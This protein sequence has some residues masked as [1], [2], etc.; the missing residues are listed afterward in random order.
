MRFSLVTFTLVAAVA[1][2][3]AAL[4][5]APASSAA[6]SGAEASARI[7]ATPGGAWKDAKG[8][9]HEG[10]DVS[11]L[12]GNDFFRFANGGWLASTEIPKDRDSWG[13]GAQVA[14]LTDERTAK[15][16]REVDPARGDASARLVADYFAA[17]MDESAIESKGLAPIAKRL[18]A[19]SDIKSKPALAK[20]L[21]GTVRA[22]V[23][24]LNATELHTAN[25]LGL[26]VAQD[27]DEPT[28]YA[29]FLLQGGLGMPDREYYLDASPRMTEMRAKYQAHVAAVLELAKVKDAPAKAARI[30][31]LE[32]KIAAT[33]AT[34]ED[35]GDAEKGNNHW[36]RK[37]LD[38][39]APGLDWNAFLGAAGLE[40]QPVFV[41]WSPKAVTGLAALVASEPL[42]TW[43]DY[44]AFHTLDHASPYLP[45]AF[46][47]EHFAFHGKAI[48]GIEELR[49]RWKRGVEATSDALGE[50]VGKLYVER[51][52]PPSEKARAQEMVKNIMAAFGR[53]IEA[54]QW[55]SPATKAKA[56]AKLATLEVGV[57][58]PD[59]FRDYSSL[60]VTRGDALGNS[61]R[62]ELFELR[63]NVAKLGNP[64][65]RGEWV[66]NPQL[67]NAV[68]LPVRNALQFPAAILQAPLFDSKR[69]AAANYGGIGA[70]IGH[71]ISHSFDDQGALFDA[72][73]K[74][75][76]WWTADDL[77][78]FKASGAA[79][80]K[81]YDAYRPFP[82]A[83]VNGKQTLGEN[84]ADLAG[85][86]AAFDA[87]QLSLGGKPA[88]EVEG[89]TGEQQFFIGFAQGWRT[90][91]R[92]A[93]ARSRLVTDG[94]APPEYRSDTVR[95]LDPW[96]AAFSPR[97][98]EALFLAPAERVRVW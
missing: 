30:V 97:P 38:T 40:K 76:N 25:V 6:P 55:M 86:S 39:K 32:K 45:K 15:L 59:K 60:Q 36:S 65:D 64:I 56:K 5:S 4:P 17:F 88:P 80:A 33:H 98:G 71:E 54:L 37:D 74:M 77:A 68:N 79:L 48:S 50:A 57:G 70:I 69:S 93:K 41:P 27:L 73:G 24:V 63:R 11:T 94:H 96:Y 14:E 67:V 49:E 23:D 51:Y 78:H 83:S 84:I 13:V 52:F 46:V 3:P 81:Q 34:R 72:T 44:L 43:K 85:L 61:E 92:E 87:Y 20:A 26:W 35:A 42:D 22:D 89:F 66:M 16:I 7:H 19:I 9:L 10:M 29:A 53:R 1:C 47:A 31:E 82:D 21:G 75:S 95:N 12:P 2:S 28:K 90:K 58:Y 8:V 18:A 91:V 62:A